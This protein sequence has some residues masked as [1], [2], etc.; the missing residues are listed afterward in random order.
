MYILSR[1]AE[2]CIFVARFTL[3]FLSRADISLRIGLWEN[4]T[5]TVETIA[6]YYVTATATEPTVLNKQVSVCQWFDSRAKYDKDFPVLSK[7]L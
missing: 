2:E 6:S 3:N 1:V 7:Q 4:L 5:C